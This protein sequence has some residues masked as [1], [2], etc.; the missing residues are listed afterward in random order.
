M[1]INSDDA[2]KTDRE[3]KRIEESKSP[4]TDHKKPRPAEPSPLILENAKIHLTDDK[5]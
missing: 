4:D 2:N 5:T 1:N 3:K